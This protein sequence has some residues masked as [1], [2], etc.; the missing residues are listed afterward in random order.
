M[1]GLLRRLSALCLCG[2]LV[3]AALSARAVSFPDVKPGSWYEKDV[4]EMAEAGLLTGLPDGTFAPEKTISWAEFVTI[5]G[6]TGTSFPPPGRAL[7][8]PSPGSLR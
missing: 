8:S 3:L 2:F 7:T 1:R 5:A 6:T 4:L